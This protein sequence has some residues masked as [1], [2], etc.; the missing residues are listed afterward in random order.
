MK[1]F[2]NSSVLHLSTKTTFNA[3]D[4]KW[5][6]FKY[7]SSNMIRMNGSRKKITKARSDK[8]E[9]SVRITARVPRYIVEALPENLR[10]RSDLIRTILRVHLGA[11][12]LLKKGEK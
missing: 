8:V 1:V 4:N 12:G 10:E 7:E 5:F 2:G 9:D 3:N 11:M 6:T